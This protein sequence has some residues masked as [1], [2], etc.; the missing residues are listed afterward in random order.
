MVP[1]DI[2]I[3]N[4]C[5]ANFK[6]HQNSDNIYIVRSKT[7]E[8]GVLDTNRLH[9]I[10]KF[11]LTD[12]TVAL[13]LLL[14][15]R[16]LFYGFTRL[17]RDNGIRDIAFIIEM[18]NI[19]RYQTEDSLGDS[20]WTLLICT[21]CTSHTTNATSVKKC[22]VGE[23]EKCDEKMEFS[24][25]G[26]ARRWHASYSKIEK[27]AFSSINT[28]CMARNEDQLDWCASIVHAYECCG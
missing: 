22:F 10:G 23:W 8:R 12:M 26:A 27:Y 9:Q 2:H 11:V 15:R 7:K 18:Q 17:T 14:Y 1:R 16:V 25:K 13:L 28:C 19:F 21:F 20:L 3:N 24:N 5:P 6:R 4:R